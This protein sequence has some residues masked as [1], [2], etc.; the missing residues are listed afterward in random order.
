V[1]IEYI[2]F[3]KKGKK[4]KSLKKNLPDWYP[5]TRDF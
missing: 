1:S 3:V 5:K 4:S 2:V